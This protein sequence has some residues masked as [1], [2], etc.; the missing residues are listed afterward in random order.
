MTVSKTLLAAGTAALIGAPA[1]ALP[2]QA[3]SHPSGPP[4]STPNDLNNPGASHRS[5]AATDALEDRAEEGNHAN[6][7]KDQGSGTQSPGNPGEPGTS[8]KCKPHRVGYVASGT[9]ESSS[10]TPNSDGTFSGSVTV[11]VTHT[12]HH[13]ANDKAKTPTETKVYPVEKVH[14]TFGLADTNND[15]SVGLDDLAKGDSV[16]LI[17]KITALAKKCSHTGFTATT[18]IRHVVFNAP[19]PS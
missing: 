10:L 1:W 7:G 9:L 12:N 13:G 18:T 11:H 14:L 2:S 5:S 3:L 6:N 17:G 15:G 19:S 4:S 8:H 16:R